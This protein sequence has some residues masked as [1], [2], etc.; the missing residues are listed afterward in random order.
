MTATFSTRFIHSF[1]SICP[2]YTGLV[3]DFSNLV[4]ESRIAPTRWPMQPEPAKEEAVPACQALSHANT[5]CS[6]PVIM[7]CMRCDQWFCQEHAADDKS[8]ECVLCEGD[9]G[10]EG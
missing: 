4:I 6:A 8:H 2:G 9:I 5:P 3:Q 1:T 10:G 7:H